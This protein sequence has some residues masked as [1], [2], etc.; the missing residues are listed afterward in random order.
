MGTIGL[1]VRRDRGIDAL[2][3]IATGPAHR[4]DGAIDALDGPRFRPWCESARSTHLPARGD[5]RE[6]DRVEH[7]RPV[8]PHGPSPRRHRHRKDARM[9]LRSSLALAALVLMVPA[10]RARAQTAYSTVSGD[11][12]IRFDLATPGNVTPIGF[13][14]GAT[15]LI[16]GLDFRVSNG[17]LYG[18]NSA[19]NVIVT[20]DPN[21]AVTTFVSNPT[22]AANTSDLGVDFN[23][24]PNLLRLVTTVGQ[25]LRISV[26]SGTT[27]VDT[28]LAYAAGDPSALGI[29]NINEVAYTNNDLDPGTGTQIYYIDY[30]HDVL[31]TVI[32]PTSPNTGP[33]TTVGPLGV[34]SLAFTGFDIFTSALGENT[35]YAVLSP[36]V[37]PEGLYTIDL[38][39]GAATPVG[40]FGNLNFVI[41]LAITPVTVAAVPEP[42]SMALLAL[43]AG[44]VGLPLLR[45]RARRR[46]IAARPA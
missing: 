19:Q 1:A 40:N 34:D 41:G 8:G 42:A 13:F 24:V 14:S 21:T 33:I 36:P 9:R 22:T 43:G 30:G 27:N 17:L 44:L 38:G 4:D 31:A 10:A 12:L 3:D 45:H 2:R 11:S 20:I 35:A 26:D 28:T 18:Y 46:T 16:D 6:V 7:L 37:G 39:T 23:P 15:N 29:T 25:N 32:P 5:H